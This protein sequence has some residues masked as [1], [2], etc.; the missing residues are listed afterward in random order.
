MKTD[1]GDKKINTINFDDDIEKKLELNELLNDIHNNP[2]LQAPPVGLGQLIT[3]ENQPVKVE[4][5]LK[6]LKFNENIELK[7]SEKYSA[8][9]KKI[10][11]TLIS[12]NT[13]KFEFDNEDVIDP[14]TMLVE[15]EIANPNKYNYLQID[16]SP[17]SII[18]STKWV[19][20]D[21]II[22][23]INDYHVLLSFLNDKEYKTNKYNKN[24]DHFKNENEEVMPL[25]YGTRE[26][27]L[28]P[29]VYGTEF[30][31]NNSVV[32]SSF[33]KKHD[34]VDG[35]IDMRPK[36]SDVFEIPI[37]SYIFGNGPN[38]KEY[39]LPLK[40]FKGL[41]LYITLNE[42]A[43]FV[44]C[45]NAT[46]NELLNISDKDDIRYE[47]YYNFMSD[48]N[49]I[50]KMESL[51]TENEMF[52]KLEEDFNNEELME[53]DE[54]LIDNYSKFR[55]MYSDI[56]KELTQYNSA[57]MKLNYIETVLCLLG[58]IYNYLDDS[59]LNKEQQNIYEIYKINH[60]LVRDLFIFK[61]CC[62]A[63]LGSKFGDIDLSTY[64]KKNNVSE[65]K[66]DCFYLVKDNNE[67]PLSV[68]YQM[69]PHD[70]MMGKY[71][72]I[73][74]LK[75]LFYANQKHKT[76][77]SINKNN[78]DQY[79]GNTLVD[80]NFI[81]FDDYNW[82]DNE[83]SFKDNWSQI[84]FSNCQSRVD[85]I[86]NM[87]DYKEKI[88]K[89]T[90]VRSFFVLNNKKMGN[91]C[92]NKCLVLSDS[93]TL[94]QFVFDNTFE[95][96][97]LIPGTSYY[98]SMN[99]N[100][101]IKL[102][103]TLGIVSNGEFCYQKNFNWQT[104]YFQPFTCNDFIK[105]FD[106]IAKKLSSNNSVLL[107]NLYRTLILYLAQS[108]LEIL[109]PYL[110]LLYQ[111]QID[112][113][114]KMY[115]KINLRDWILLILYYELDKEMRITYAK[116]RMPD[117]LKIVEDIPTS[118]VKNRYRYEKTKL[119]KKLTQCM[120][121]YKKINQLKNKYN[122]VVSREYDLVSYNFTYVSYKNKDGS[123]IQISNAW[124]GD[125][126]Y[127][128]LMDKREFGTHPPSKLFCYMPSNNV[129]NIYQI[130]LSDAYKT[131][132]TCRFSSRYNRKIKNY[133]IETEFGNYPKEINK[134]DN[135]SYTDSN[136]I[137]HR[138][139]E[140]FNVKN[141]CLNKYNTA[142]D[143]NTQLYITKKL[144]GEESNLIMFSDYANQQDNYLFGHF[145]EIN[146][147][148]IFGINIK[149]LKR[150]L[151]LEDKVLKEFYIRM[152]S[153]LPYS[154]TDNFNNY[155]IYTFAEGYIHYDFD[156]FGNLKTGNIIQ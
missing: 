50:K 143:N 88:N 82:N 21:K 9:E 107:E 58:K 136:L 150:E 16:N 116:T 45:F 43:F 12:N 62:Y 19:Y 15:I 114:V 127:Y 1:N 73:D 155:E 86:E 34:I 81:D 122:V 115:N 51:M 149:K 89:I 44:P 120:E 85:F 46:I 48:Y 100:T 106:D 129:T 151:K 105:T 99:S 84:A 137:Y 14:E 152:Q 29:K 57:N 74:F 121:E 144:N 39:L 91:G 56:C 49:T 76:N 30:I 65:F 90:E 66:F 97:Y 13:I 131:Y 23:N 96:F 52:C 27:L 71:R 103:T 47:S 6:D 32:M 124:S 11:G 41:Q 111:S 125:S 101:S 42:F 133:W 130:I 146:S 17:H 36:T 28:H 33:I 148:C 38:K 117:L 24:M 75:A 37:F 109:I 126:K 113:N 20:R 22:E 53:L 128:I 123:Q 138:L 102:N 135:T 77:L 35:L 61:I 31:F 63:N 87:N 110:Y 142:M 140:C 5:M 145:T 70:Y 78:F 69:V 26:Q 119:K 92:L 60:K 83:L 147:K 108:P 72:C 3:V 55:I 54:G 156:E 98:I 154:Q 40:M 8:K 64:I 79:P 4:H 68:L 2:I 139:K 93:K 132:P 59:C 7:L 67:E 118:F 10:E 95:L 134:D 25:T 104:K 153:D 18:K 112:D 141:S 80:I 94:P